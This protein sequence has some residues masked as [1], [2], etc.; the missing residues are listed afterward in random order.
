MSEANK[1]NF[2]VFTIKLNDYKILGLFFPAID[3][4]KMGDCYGTFENNQSLRAIINEHAQIGDREIGTMY[5][6][7]DPS[8]NELQNFL[9]GGI[10]TGVDDVPEGATMMDFPASEFLV[11]T[12]K[13]CA[14]EQELMESGLI[15]ETIG[16]AHSDDVK[17]PD[18]YERYEYP[19]GYRERWNFIP[20]ENKFRLEVWFAI[21][22]K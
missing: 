19:V 5:S 14:T 1:S 18:G 8:N 22:K 10:V 4:R 12:H 3:P 9:L 15:A 6:A 20:D 2:E 7:N 16:Y 21:R 11:V 13:W 17:M